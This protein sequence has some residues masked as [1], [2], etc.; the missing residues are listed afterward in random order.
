MAA[1]E[2]SEAE[3][4]TAKDI[5]QKMQGEMDAN[6]ASVQRHLSAISTEAE[7]VVNSHPDDALV[8]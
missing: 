3:V 5:R 7:A 6:A 2:V 8:A 1:D 4:R